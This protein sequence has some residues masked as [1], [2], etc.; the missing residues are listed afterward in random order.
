MKKIL[1]TLALLISF[2]SFGQT[3]EQYFEMGNE[4]QDNFD[5]NGALADYTKAIEINPNYSRAYVNRGDIKVLAGFEDYYGAIADYTKA[6]EILK[7]RLTTRLDYIYASRAYAKRSL[8]DNKGAI[9]DYTKAIEIN[10]NDKYSYNAMGL[11]KF[12]LEDYYGAIADYTKAM[13][14]SGVDSKYFDTYAYENRGNAKKKLGDLKGACED[15]K[16]AVDLG[17]ISKLFSQNCN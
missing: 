9:A 6:I 17:S 7:D 1:F 8:G 11:S 16:K 2:S 4:K 12:A 5:Y 15:F 3:A 13:E 10:P 14:I